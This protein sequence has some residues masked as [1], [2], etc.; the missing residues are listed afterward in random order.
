MALQAIA[1]AVLKALKEHGP[2]GAFDLAK[3]EPTLKKNTLQNL[4]A[5][6]YVRQDTTSTKRSHNIK[7]MLTPNGHQALST[8]PSKPTAKVRK[9]KKATVDKTYVATPRIP[10]TTGP[11]T[12]S[13]N[14]CHRPGALDAFSKPSLVM[15]S[16]VFNHTR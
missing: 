1:M 9:N 4:K 6:G 13:I 14:T 12:P 5:A 15:G 2:T 7:W 3:I 16:R 11:L 10:V 8:D